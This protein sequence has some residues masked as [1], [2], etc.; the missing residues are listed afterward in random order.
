MYKIID[1]IYIGNIWDAYD[2]ESIEKNKIKTIISLLDNNET[3]NDN[4]LYKKNIILKKYNILNEYKYR[5]AI[6]PIAEDI[7]NIINSSGDNILI[8]CFDCKSL[9]IVVIIYYLIKQY[10]YSYEKA[11]DFIYNINSNIEI[12]P[13]FNLELKQL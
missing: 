5:Y 1:G 2:L 11:Y 6:L 9:S 10:N 13:A 7:F 12:Y 8:Y 4:E 3:N